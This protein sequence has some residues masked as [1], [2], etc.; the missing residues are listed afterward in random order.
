M[1]ARSGV[2]ID[3]NSIGEGHFETDK[4]ARRTGPQCRAETG[5]VGKY[6]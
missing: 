5:E 6:F 4:T 3:E 1:V 2:A